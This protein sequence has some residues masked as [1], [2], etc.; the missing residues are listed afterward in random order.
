MQNKL[1]AQLE[2]AAPGRRPAAF[3]SAASST[4]AEPAATTTGQTA[5]AQVGQAPAAEPCAALLHPRCA[6]N[7]CAL[8]AQGALAS[9][10]TATNRISSLCLAGTSPLGGAERSHFAARRSLHHR[11]KRGQGRL[12]S[13]EATDR[14]LLS[15]SFFFFSSSHHTRMIRNQRSRARQSSSEVTTTGAAHAGT[16]LTGGHHRLVGT[17]QQWQR[18]ACSAIHVF[19]SRRPVQWF[20]ALSGSRS[21]HDAECNIAVNAGDAR[22]R[23]WP[24]GPV[25]RAGRRSRRL[26]RTLD[27]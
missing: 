26:G 9:S 24:T 18:R 22:R 4:L 14:L 19:A 10:C 12:H 6:S 7:L 17:T 8:S 2:L 3:C 21:P 15:S 27:T 16:L 13:R 20:V 5:A 11:G 25:G 1:A 23:R